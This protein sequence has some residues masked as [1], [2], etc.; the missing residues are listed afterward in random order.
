MNQPKKVLIVDDEQKILEIIEIYLKNAGYIVFKEENGKEAID[1]FE[2]NKPDLVILDLMLPDISGED[3]CRYITKKS[4]T[5][6]IMLTAKVSSESV[7]KG[8]ELGAD[9]Y[10]T[11]PFVAKELVARVNALLRRTST[12]DRNKDSDTLSFNNGDL[13][14]SLKNINAIRNGKNLNLTS[15][16][17]GLLSLLAKNRNKIFT[18][19]EIINYIYNYDFD[20]YDRTIDAHIKNLRHKIEDDTKNPKYIITIHS[21]GYKFGGS[22]DEN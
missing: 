7:V 14:I 15:K 18:R 5:P 19:E 1:C 11:K 4:S 10:I 13:V 21:I 20:G 17:F 16:E 8:L 12:T 9:E 3:V 2:K 6:V 22:L